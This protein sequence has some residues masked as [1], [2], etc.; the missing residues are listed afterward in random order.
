MVTS[1][2]F[3]DYSDYTRKK[4]LNV[5]ETRS[6]NERILLSFYNFSFFF[7]RERLLNVKGC[8][9]LR[10]TAA[11]FRKTSRTAEKVRSLSHQFRIIEWTV[12]FISTTQII[13]ISK[14]QLVP[15]VSLWTKRLQFQ[16][17]FFPNAHS[18]FRLTHFWPRR[19]EHAWKMN[20]GKAE[21]KVS[22]SFFFSPL[23]RIS[24]I[25]VES[26]DRFEPVFFHVR[27]DL[28][29]EIKKKRK[30]K[31]WGKMKRSKTC[32]R[33]NV[34]DRDIITIPGGWYFVTVFCDVKRFN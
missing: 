27:S 31:N 14:I 30:K 33:D 2:K 9:R 23:P 28:H 22:E 17:T 11:S 13:D 32:T 20:K 34:G 8:T 3:K 5:N 4:K 16:T 24:G 10:G 25:S 29:W 1:K 21:G 26:R 6:C 12:E 18:K 7:T 15:S 19:I